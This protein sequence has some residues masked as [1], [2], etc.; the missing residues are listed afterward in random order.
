MVTPTALR[1]ATVA[2]AAPAPNHPC[3]SIIT[4]TDKVQL[5]TFCNLSEYHW[6]CLITTAAD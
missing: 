1:P 2:V 3:L 6:Q 5:A 4:T